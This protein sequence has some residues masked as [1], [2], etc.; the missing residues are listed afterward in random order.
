MIDTHQH[1]IDPSRFAYGWS[2]DLP[3][4]QGAFGLKEYRSAAAD[5]S[6]DGTIFM[7]V[8]VDEGQS[9]SEAAFFCGL[10][11][12]ATNQI[13][14]VVAS[15]RPENHDF[16]QSLD[17]IAHP[18][19]KGIRRVLHTQPDELSQGTLFRANIARLAERDL[20][21]DLCVLQ[22]QLGVAHQLVQAC[23]DTRFIL[24]HCGVP[25]FANNN[26]PHGD[27]WKQWQTD[28]H[29]LAGR[30]N[31]FG[32]LS[33]ITANAAPE[34]RN[35]TCLQ[36]YVSTMIEAFGPHRLVWGS[37][38]PVVNLGSGFTTWAALTN[39]LLG[40]LSPADCELILSRNARS[41]YRISS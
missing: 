7:E 26:A 23:P 27:G 11:E 41:I 36:P 19:L 12:D 17:L 13:L 20:S 4:L 10:A 28:I 35:G 34:Q 9:A 25:D 5:V 37:D 32:K 40:G 31:V 14:G 30:P 22:R 39:E 18:K 24:D 16:A 1:L 38:W 15:A 29:A 2:K 6:I 3:A 8:D 33:G 21:F